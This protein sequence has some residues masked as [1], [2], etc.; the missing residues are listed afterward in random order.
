MRESERNAPATKFERGGGERGI[1]SSFIHNTIG[2]ILGGEKGGKRKNRLLSRE[3]SGRT[4]EKKKG[5]KRK[6]LATSP[7]F[8]LRTGSRARGKGKGGRKRGLRSNRRALFPVRMR[9]ARTHAC[10][11]LVIPKWR[12]KEKKK[13]KKRAYW[14]S[15][16]SC[17]KCTASG[18]GPPGV[19]SQ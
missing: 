4:G 17:I 7:S 19:S 6:T 11:K 13:G 18:N 10:Q 16:H 9:T 5:R 12:E 14:P 2:G 15:R 8:L 1:G 3:A